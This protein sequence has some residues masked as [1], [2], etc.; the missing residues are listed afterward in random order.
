MR[1]LLDDSIL[2]AE[3]APAMTL[4]P[5]RE[6]A[7]IDVLAA[8]WRRRGLVLGFVAAG[9][10]LAL[11]ALMLI[12]PL[13]Q[14]ESVVQLDLRTVELG[15][16]KPV[17]LSPL[18]D[19]PN[20][21][22]RSEVDLIRSAAIARDVVA[23]LDL[24]ADPEFN[25]FLG[26]RVVSFDGLSRFLHRLQSLRRAESGQ[27]TAGVD[28]PNPQQVEAAVVKA[29]L[30]RLEVE[31]DGKSYT[32]FIRFASADAAKA[33]TIAN[34]FA[35]RYL[36][37]QVQ[38]NTRTSQDVSEWLRRQ[39]FSAREQVREA[40][41]AIQAYRTEHGLVGPAGT[42][43][44]DAGSRL[45]EINRQLADAAAA[46]V[47]LE[48]RVKLVNERAAA[49]TDG[50]ISEV[51]ASPAIQ[52][53]QQAQVALMRQRAE[54]G[55]LYADGHP[56]LKR[57]DAEAREID[58]RIR[59]ETQRIN[60]AIT[61]ELRIAV[62]RE[63]RLKTQLE[64]LRASVDDMDRRQ[65]R[66]RELELE[67]ESK[68]TL[69]RSIATSHQQTQ[70]ML[71]INR[72][73]GRLVAEATVPLY[74]DS[75][76]PAVVLMIA[77]AGAL[78]AAAVAAARLERDDGFAS[79]RDVETLLE[80][81]CLATVPSVGCS[82]RRV[83]FG[84]RPQADH[85]RALFA[86]AMRTACTRIL[87]LMP[88]QQPRLLTV[89]SSLGDEG[90]SVCAVS[91]ACAFAGLGMKTLVIDADFRRPTVSK[92]IGSGNGPSLAEALSEK[93]SFASALQ[94]AAEK[95]LYVLGNRRPIENGSGLLASAAI[96]RLMRW[97]GEAFDIVIVDTPPVML[98]ADALAFAPLSGAVLYAVHWKKT[99]KEAVRAGFLR[100]DDAN[101]R[102]LGVMLTRVD[103]GH[104]AD[105][106]QPPNRAIDLIPQPERRA[107]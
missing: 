39:L 32:I 79:A 101:A 82:D 1:P 88:S 37:Q 17:F 23:H 71:D 50:A 87:T 12:R 64:N 27:A 65:A 81:P 97:A 15:E 62:E 8:M 30:R 72:V 41:A 2:R 4:M 21:R 53:L 49:G 13:Y 75:P 22:L 18:A 69:F 68:R 100:L 40:E 31:N 84:R 24:A 16:L 10:V 60:G 11:V 52:N 38:A 45:S 104:A 26:A 55:V 7:L 9:L 76:M 91:L 14:A 77:L 73:S 95:N 3:H 61:G 103:V 6:R 93:V 86:E 96:E 99:P 105:P 70:A 89:T 5:R 58:R 25:P 33:A 57:L 66:L 102:V 20:V 67:A 59:Q 47:A 80:V 78:L 48:A 85:V 107:A 44:G 56:A 92:L 19:Q 90:K 94:P 34:A 106:I 51:L 29:V 63:R 36:E 74:P 54:I 43:L 83:S 35:Q 28:S 42:D 46:R 98:A